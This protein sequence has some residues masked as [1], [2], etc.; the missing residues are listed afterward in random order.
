MREK[1]ASRTSAVRVH[2]SADNEIT[3][4]ALDCDTVEYERTD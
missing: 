2:V 3:G 1:I 4:L